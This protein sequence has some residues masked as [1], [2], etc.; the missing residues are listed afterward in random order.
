MA[1]AELESQAALADLIQSNSNVC[2]TFSATW[3]G[4]CQRSKPD[5][6]ELAN[7]YKA[8]SSMQ[9]AMGIIYEHVL[10]EAIHEYSVRAFPTYVL[11][12]GGKETN[13]VEGANL[14]AVQDMIAKGNCT[15]IATTGGETLGGGQVAMS[16]ADARA[17]RLAKLEGNTKATAPPPPVSPS[18]PEPMDTSE[19]KPAA[20]SVKEADATKIEDG[21]EPMQED[22]PEVEDVTANLDPEAIKT[23]TESMGFNLVRAQKGLL[24]GNGGN[25]ESAV[26]WLM[27]HQDDDDIDTA[28]PKGPL[29]KMQSYKCNECG[30][31]LSN[32]ANL[33]LHANKTGHSD[34]EES[35]TAVK[36]LT[37][38]EKKAK[39]AEIKE[40]LRLKRAEREEIEKVDDI[41]R[42]KQ[43]RNMGKEM[44]KTK[45]QMEAEARKRDAARIKREKEAF[46]RERARL[47]AELEKDKAERKA[48]AG[49]LKGRLGVEGY[50]PDGIQ[51][52]VPLEGEDNKQ[53][54]A[55]NAPSP[56]R[57]KL[58]ADAGKIDEY[59]KKVSSYKAGGDGGKCLKILKTY[60]GNVVDNPDE[61]KY[62]SI[63]MDNKAFK[64]KVKPFVGS[65]QL[66]MAV[67]FAPNKA[68]DALV[69]DEEDVN[70]ELLATT[71]AKLEA[72][73][74]AY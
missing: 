36:P 66:L 1:L 23:L 11:F 12:Q 14:P 71:K 22:K 6:Q 67:G 30:K 72:A 3:C 50:Q 24:Y 55:T 26:E 7:K 48:N 60:V 15:A 43:R 63:N 25:V 37:E 17:A 53:A 13:R 8:D 16:A 10:G 65:K 58:K 28:I 21:T 69:L 38:E 54:A 2:I 20:S 46:K 44:L 57:K 33:E 34:F 27:E 29:Q 18:G 31:I 32:M 52:D 56:E 70:A 74:A 39:I 35:T 61:P 59:I 51:Y 40:L 62:K 73:L 47:R 41:T 4:P 68:G 5:L 19:D 42:E 45:E 9:L 49:K 64:T